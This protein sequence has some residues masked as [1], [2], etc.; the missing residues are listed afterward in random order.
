[1]DVCS[2]ILVMQT[3]AAWRF[4]CSEKIDAESNADAIRKVSRNRPGGKLDVEVLFPLDSN[5]RSHRVVVATWRLVVVAWHL[6]SAGRP[7]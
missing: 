4:P 5:C 1:M 3:G 7:L 6:R 2:T